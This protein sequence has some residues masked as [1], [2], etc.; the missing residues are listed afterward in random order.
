MI[1]KAYILFV[2]I[3]CLQVVR[4]Q[5]MEVE[6]DTCDTRH[7]LPTKITAANSNASWMLATD[8]ISPIIFIGAGILGGFTV[9]VSSLRW[10]G[11]SDLH[12]HW[13]LFSNEAHF[14]L[15]PTEVSFEPITFRQEPKPRRRLLMVDDSSALHHSAFAFTN[16]HSLD[17]TT[18]KPITMNR[19]KSL[20]FEALRSII[21]LSACF[22]LGFFLAFIA[23]V[24]SR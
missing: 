18:T 10:D 7:A 9:P 22:C 17:S 8:S 23:G 6:N 15:G 12:I 21:Q 24:V 4:A 19:Q 3:A 20:L 14:Q 16:I 1:G 13:N 5:M 2:A 11:T